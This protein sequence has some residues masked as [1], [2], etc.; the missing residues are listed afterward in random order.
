MA[1]QCTVVIEVDTLFCLSQ[2]THKNISHVCVVVSSLIT[3]PQ[4]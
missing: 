4:D 3:G 2:L 1:A